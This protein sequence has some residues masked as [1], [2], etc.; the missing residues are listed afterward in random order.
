MAAAREAGDHDRVVSIA[1]ALRPDV[2]FDRSREVDYWVD[3]GGA[4]SRLRGRS[5]DAALAFRRAE[6]ISPRHVHRN[7]L[8]REALAVL[9]ARS[10][11]D[12][13]VGRELRRMAYQAGL[14]V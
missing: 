7:P 13:P 14:P 11:R 10:R 12:S 3:Y 4:L 2:H 5:D 9:L 8:V 1:E 6:V